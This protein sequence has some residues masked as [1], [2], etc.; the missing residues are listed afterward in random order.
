MSPL[1][2]L[3][4]IARIT[5]SYDTWPA[6]LSVFGATDDRI[7][8]HRIASCPE[9]G[10]ASVER[11][12]YCVHEWLLV[13]TDRNQNHLRLTPVPRVFREGRV[14]SYGSFSIAL[15]A[16]EKARITRAGGQVPFVAVS[17]LHTQ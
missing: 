2:S 3:T 6:V 13:W 17:F 16:G 1:V 7:A 10:T 12:H 9:R 5:Q 15:D 11:P 4:R 14:M 8:S